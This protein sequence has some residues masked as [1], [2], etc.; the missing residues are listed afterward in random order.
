MSGFD[1]FNLFGQFLCLADRIHHQPLKCSL[2]AGFTPD[3]RVTSANLTQ[4][5]RAPAARGTRNKGCCCWSPLYLCGISGRH[6]PLSSI[7]S[8]KLINKV[9][10]N[11]N[12]AGKPGFSFIVDLLVVSAL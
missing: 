6:L 1:N 8:T 9:A 5:L 10:G 2:R 7:V 11:I 12:H 4:M 3:A